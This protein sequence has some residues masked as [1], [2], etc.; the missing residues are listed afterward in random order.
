LRRFP[1]L[2]P[3][4]ILKQKSSF[5]MQ[6]TRRGLSGTPLTSRSSP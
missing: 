6:P 1:A 5:M 2:Q 4:T 3:A